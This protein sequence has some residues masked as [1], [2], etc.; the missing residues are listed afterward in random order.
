MAHVKWGRYEPGI[1]RRPNPDDPGNWIYR[2]VRQAG[3]TEDG[4][5]IQQTKNT[6]RLKDARLFRSTG[7]VKRDEGALETRKDSLQALYDRLHESEHYAEATLRWHADLWANIPDRLKKVPAKDVNQHDIDGL[8]GKIKAPVLRERVRGLISELYAFGGL[9][10]NPAAKTRRPTTRTA[11]KARR[12]SLRNELRRLQDDEL[13][14]LIAEMPARYWALV[15]LMAW[16]GL[17]PGEAYALRVGKF[18]PTRKTLVIDT[19]VSGETKTGESRTLDGTMLP[20]GL[21][22]HLSDHIDWFSSWDADALIFPSDEGKMIDLGNFRSRVFQPACKR[23]GL[24]ALAPK[25]LRHTAVARAIHRGANVYQVQK[26]VGHA[27]ASITLD[28]YGFLW[29]VEDNRLAEGLQQAWA[30]RKPTA[31]GQVIPLA[32]PGS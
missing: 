30:D 32:A 13:E 5:Y 23:A 29:E 27:R 17:R 11:R 8:M 2:A 14:R 19:A 22:E 26:M 15:E 1:Y 12:T 7:E 9:S 20:D 10:V 3:K 24:V 25:D 28:V 31:A 6:H 16:A 18:N 4:R 21:I